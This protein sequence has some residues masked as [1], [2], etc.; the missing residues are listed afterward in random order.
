MLECS[1]WVEKVPRGAECGKSA[2]KQNGNLAHGISTWATP[3]AIWRLLLLG[4]PLA[5]QKET[6][7]S[8]LP[9]NPTTCATFPKTTQK[10][11]ELPKPPHLALRCN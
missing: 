3:W 7:G 10:L 6:A 5:S 9:P 8:A 11:S 4:G 2:P 1:G